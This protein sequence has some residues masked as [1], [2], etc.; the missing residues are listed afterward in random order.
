MSSVSETTMVT[1]IFSENDFFT[2]PDSL[3][4]PA[5]D[6]DNIIINLSL[7]IKLLIKIKVLY[8]AKLPC[9]SGNNYGNS[10]KLTILVSVDESTTDLDFDGNNYCTAVF[11]V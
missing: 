1:R 8:L 10:H 11:T 9:H 2:P 4:P 6:G 7:I 3:L 5:S